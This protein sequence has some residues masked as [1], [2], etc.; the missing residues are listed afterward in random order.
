MTFI[1]KARRIANDTRFKEKIGDALEDAANAFF[2]NPVSAAKF[3]KFLLESPIMIRE[4]LFWNKFTRFTEP[5]V[6]D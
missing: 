5:L 4:R 3:I 6:N 2:G 1:E